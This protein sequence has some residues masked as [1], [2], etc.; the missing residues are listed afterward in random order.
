MKN[1]LLTFILLSA[2]IS[3]HGTLFD[4]FHCKA[5]TC[6][7]FYYGLKSFPN[8]KHYVN[9]CY[10][11]VRSIENISKRYDKCFDERTAK[12]NPPCIYALATTMKRCIIGLSGVPEYYARYHCGYRLMQNCAKNIGLERFPYNI[13]YQR[14]DDA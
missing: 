12:F 2:I 10:N 6:H 1:F 5:A 4:S 3:I 11:T 14:L 8:Q 7:E 9:V 13:E